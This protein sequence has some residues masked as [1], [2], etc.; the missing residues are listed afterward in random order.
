LPLLVIK[1]ADLILFL[2]GGEENN[3]KG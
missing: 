1:I 3:F 2:Y